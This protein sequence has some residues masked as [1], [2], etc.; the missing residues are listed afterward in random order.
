LTNGV[1]IKLAHQGTL[2]IAVHASFIDTDMAAGIDAPKIKP[3]ISRAASLRR[4]RG[5]RD[6]GARRRAVPIRQGIAVA[7]SRADLPA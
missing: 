3:G 5:R 2:V 4:R 6:Q 1:R 7:R